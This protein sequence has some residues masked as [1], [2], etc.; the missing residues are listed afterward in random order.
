[1]WSRSIT[2]AKADNP[3]YIQNMY[4]TLKANAA[5]IAYESYFNCPIVHRLH[6]DTPFPKAS[7]AYRQLW[8][9]GK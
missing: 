3:L 9:A 5:T 2:P 4:K 6:P 1:M 8:S 7:V